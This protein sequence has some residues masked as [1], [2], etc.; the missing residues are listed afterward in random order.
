MVNTEFYILTTTYM[1]EIIEVSNK[2]KKESEYNEKYKV[3]CFCEPQLGKRGL[4]PTVSHKGQYNEVRKLTNLIAYADGQ[5][6]LID[7][8][9]RIGVPI[10]EMIEN[11]DKL[12]EN[13]LFVKV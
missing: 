13:E 9:N 12:L 1:N 6:D 10:E 5:N 2:K 8:S 7:I 11:I 4:Y 3:T